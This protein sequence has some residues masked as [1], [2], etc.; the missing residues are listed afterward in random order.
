MS[1]A[2]NY[3]DLP[4][5]LPVPVD[6]GACGHLPGMPLPTVPLSSTAGRQVDLA[7]LSGRT[8]V[9]CYPATGKPGQ[10][11]PPGWDAIPGARGC[12]PQ[13]CAFRDHHGDLQA[14]GVRVFGLSTQ[15]TADQ[16]EAAARLRLPYDLLSDANLAF[17]RA[18]RLPTFAVE[19]RTYVKRLTLVI[20]EGVIEHVFYPVFP[21]NA[22]AGEVIRWLSAHPLPA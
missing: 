3:Y 18:L 10:P 7:R 15:S 11:L 21:P 13:S 14:Q 22:N 9:Y 6:D 12:T 1:G 2:D 8:V 20:H 4:P 16:Q 19:G 5:N 17:I